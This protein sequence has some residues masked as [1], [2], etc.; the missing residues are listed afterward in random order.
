MIKNYKIIEPLNSGNFGIIYKCEKDGKLYALKEEKDQLGLLKHEADIYKHLKR[1]NFIPK[2]HEFFTLSKKPYLV[3]DLLQYNLKSYKHANYQNENYYRKTLTI[4]ITI[5]GI[6][7]DIHE[8]GVVHRDLAPENICFNEKDEPYIIDFGIAKHI[9]HKNDHI[10]QRTIKSPLGTPNYMSINVLNLVEPS[11]RDDIES[12]FYILLYLYMTSNDYE[13]Y[14]ALP[15]QKKK[16]PAIIIQILNNID[17]ISQNKAT[18]LMD[19]LLYAR[20]LRFDQ[21]PNYSYILNLLWKCQ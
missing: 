7:K 12:L 6:L 8:K 15:I 18:F 2:M 3:L 21:R 10:E 19:I 16:D 5:M 11:R 4:V 9:I 20:K 1:V 13:Q 14:N 17:L